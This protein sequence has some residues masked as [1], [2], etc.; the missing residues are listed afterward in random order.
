MKSIQKTILQKRVLTKVMTLRKYPQSTTYP[1]FA[2][3]SLYFSRHDWQSIYA[4]RFWNYRKFQIKLTKSK[5]KFER[6]DR[7]TFQLTSQYRSWC[8]YSLFKFLPNQS[9]K[10]RS[11]RLFC[12]KLTKKDTKKINNVI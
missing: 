6:S 11:K 5:A 3:V 1:H 9:A 8:I 2:Q 10:T 12:S 7:F 4:E